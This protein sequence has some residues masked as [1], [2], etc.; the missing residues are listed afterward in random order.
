MAEASGVGFILTSHETFGVLERSGVMRAMATE[1][2]RSAPS[3]R[4]FNRCQRATIRKRNGPLSMVGDGG[5]RAK[6]HD[7]GGKAG[8]A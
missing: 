6:T 5:L 3:S 7:M 4:P 8:T 1:I 2:G